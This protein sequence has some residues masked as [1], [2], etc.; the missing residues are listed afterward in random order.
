ML[1]H[2]RQ[3]FP[4]DFAQFSAGYDLGGLAMALAAKSRR[5]EEPWGR[6]GLK[7]RRAGY[8][9]EANSSESVTSSN[10]LSLSPE[11]MVG[12]VRCV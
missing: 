5:T 7:R 8:L 2:A 10:P 1:R 11:M 6:R 3:L 4:Q 12:S 9:S